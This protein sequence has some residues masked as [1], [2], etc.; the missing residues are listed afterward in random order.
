VPSRSRLTGA[1]VTVT[2]PGATLAYDDHGNTTVLADQTLT[3]DVAD[4]HVKTVLTDGTSIT[5]LLDAGGS[6]GATH[7]RRSEHD[8]G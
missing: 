7:S 4:R 1:S 5:Y 6:D 8:R 2:G 3:Y